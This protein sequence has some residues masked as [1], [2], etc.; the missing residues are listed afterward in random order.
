[1]PLLFSIIVSTHGTDPS[2]FAALLKNSDP[3]AELIIAD[4][5]YDP[6]K[7]Q[8]LRDSNYAQ[9]V[10]VPIP[11]RLFPRDFCV[12]LNTALSFAEGEYIIRADD[13]LEFHKD[14][15]TIAREDI[16]KFPDYLIIG[17][18]SHAPEEEPWRDY[19]S[20]RGFFPSERYVQI[21]DPAFTFS[22]GIVKREILD[23]V[24]GWDERYDVSPV[25]E[26]ID[27]LHRLMIYL[28]GRVLLDKKLMGYGYRHSR[29]RFA[30]PLG[31]ILYALS[32]PEI[33]NGK[34]VAYNHRII[35]AARAEALAV[36]SEYIVR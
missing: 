31:T 11:Y 8:Y 3:E 7:K 17:Q 25:G 13:Y 27:I 4:S 28:Q 26:D 32:K 19:Y 5:T 9:I 15:F 34:F 24:N 18:K 30:M 16:E 29:I 35:R 22:F 20:E 33:E 23:D 1:M 12:G 2:V 10:Y 6:E 36:K 21:I 14:F